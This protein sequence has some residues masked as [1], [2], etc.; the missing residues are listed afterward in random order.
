MGGP[1]RYLAHTLGCRA[2]G[3][4]LTES[5]VAGASSLTKLAKLD[6]LVNFEHGNALDLPFP[7]DHFDVVIAQEAWGAHS[8]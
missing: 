7:D 6:A 8:T 3:I 4:D 1:V 5:R 2:T